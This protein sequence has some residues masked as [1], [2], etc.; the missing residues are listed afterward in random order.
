MYKLH[1]YDSNGYLNW[2]KERAIEITPT[3]QAVFAT[4]MDKINAKDWQ[5]KVQQQHSEWQ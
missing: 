2:I 5:K 1:T 4:R 3:W